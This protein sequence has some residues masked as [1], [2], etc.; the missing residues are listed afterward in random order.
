MAARVVGGSAIIDIDT[1]APPRTAAPGSLHVAAPE[2]FVP[3]L[4]NVRA[5][6]LLILF[7]ELVAVVLSLAAEHPS[8]ARFGWLSL[9]VQWNVLACG[10]ALCATRSV[11]ARWPLWAGA[12]GAWVLIIVVTLLV[13]VL[14]WQVAE[15]VMFARDTSFD[16]LRNGALAALVGGMA[17]RYFFVQQQWRLEQASALQSR[18]QALQSR[19]RP[20]FLFNSMN[21]IA[22]LIPVDPDNAEAVVEDLSALFRASLNEAGNQVPLEHELMLC[23]RYLRI[24]ALRLDERLRVEWQLDDLPRG[25]RIPQLTLQPLVENAIYH[26]IQPLPEGGTVR[27]EARYVD[28]VVHVRVTNPVP[29]EGA[30]T[31]DGRARATAGNGIAVQNIRTR[32]EA[33]YGD[34][35]RLHGA[36]RGDMWE[37]DLRYPF[38][39]SALLPAA[40]AG[41]ASPGQ[42]Q[43][44][45]GR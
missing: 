3:D 12:S 6:S 17:L 20:H 31:P 18:I 2:F 42:A 22:S 23:R 26:G 7:A 15:R 1:S 13:T 14:G 11:M 9:F 4:C 33:L 41:Q 44:R 35:V 8:W 28:G 37:V 16:L 5:L 10:A 24:E 25:L 34:S 36:R 27:I 19:I 43:V 29:P 39:A 30:L 21:I 40:G 32:L 45:Q 38:P